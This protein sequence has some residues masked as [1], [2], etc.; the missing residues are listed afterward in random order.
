[1]E[2]CWAHPIAEPPN[3]HSESSDGAKV[4]RVPAAE[5]GRDGEQHRAAPHPLP[6]SRMSRRG[7]EE[8]L[9]A[10]GLTGDRAEKREAKQQPPARSCPA[11]YPLPSHAPSLEFFWLLETMQPPQRIWDLL[12]TRPSP[13]IS[14]AP[15]KQTFTPGDSSASP[16]EPAGALPPLPNN[17]RPGRDSRCHQEQLL[18]RCPCPAPCCQALQGSGG[19]PCSGHSGRAGAV[20]LPG[21]KEPRSQDTTLHPRHETPR[22]HVLPSLLGQGQKKNREQRQKC[23]QLQLETQLHPNSKALCAAGSGPMHMEKCYF[24]KVGEGAARGTAMVRW[25]LKAIV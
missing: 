22:E 16:A 18:Q 23:C 19:F 14:A 10:A 4:P 13:M 24:I 2:Q 11:P 3:S 1:M 21:S 5:P 17:S 20:A 15:P 7:C 12:S 6:M 25:L 8:P 9:K